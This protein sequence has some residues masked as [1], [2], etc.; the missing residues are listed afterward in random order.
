MAH[1][2]KIARLP[3]TLR[4]AV[5]LALQDGAPARRIIQLI[6]EAKGHGA[7]NGDQTEIQIPNEQ[8]VTN[9]LQGGYKDWLAEN[10]RL[11]DMQQKREFALRIVQENE[12]GKIHEAGL[13][14]AASQIFELLQDFDVSTLK[15]QL[16]EDPENYSKVVSALA[17][18]SKEALGFEK[19]RAAVKEVLNSTEI[20]KLR[21]TKAELGDADRKAIVAKVDEILGLK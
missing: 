17:R 1:T 14:L 16:A 4:D 9:W 19:Y 6:T 5:N 20:K 7:K 3:K 8:N 21:D 11:A 18:I 13:N 10:S 12:G 15:E 2:G